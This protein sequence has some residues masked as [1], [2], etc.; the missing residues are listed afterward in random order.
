M[1]EKLSAWF[2]RARNG[3]FLILAR[4]L[5]FLSLPFAVGIPVAFFDPGI[6]TRKH[7]FAG[8][9]TATLIATGLWLFRREK[10][11]YMKAIERVPNLKPT[12]VFA[13]RYNGVGIDE[14]TRMVVTA[15]RMKGRLTVRA[16][17]FSD[18]KRVSDYYATKTFTVKRRGEPSAA[19]AVAG[20]LQYG[21]AGAVLGSVLASKKT[22]RKEDQVVEMGVQLDFD[23]SSEQ[24][25]IHRLFTPQKHEDVPP[26]RRDTVE[27]VRQHIGDAVR[28]TAVVTEREDGQSTIIEE[29]S[30]KPP[31]KQQRLFAYQ[32]CPQCKTESPRNSR[33]C[34]NCGRRRSP[35]VRHATA[36]QQRQERA[37]TKSHHGT[38][39]TTKQ[40]GLFAYQVCPQCKT[41]SPRNSRYCLNCGR[42]CSPTA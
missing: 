29:Q 22:A 8:V 39:Q 28:R 25:A 42:R 6:S 34:L 7:V 35:T 4:V 10:S 38:S 3:K 9:M 18:V 12:Y 23:D 14:E 11:L 2:E 1:L 16:R 26:R 32:V 27:T 20:G 5:L 37:E 33:Y 13:N 41:E 21:L 36:E 31:D 17:P 15:R 40:Q 24:I 30:R 19:G